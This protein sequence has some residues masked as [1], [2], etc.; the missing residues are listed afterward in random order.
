MLRDQSIGT[1]IFNP[2]NSSFNLGKTGIAISK[3]S[4]VQVGTGQLKERQAATIFYGRWAHT[5]Y[6]LDSNPSGNLTG[7]CP[8]PVPNGLEITDITKYA[9]IT[10][11]VGLAISSKSTQKDAAFKFIEY[12]FTKGMEE[13][14]KIGYNIPGNKLVAQTTFLSDTSISEKDKK[15]NEFFY[16]LAENHSFVIESNRYLS[17]SVVEN[18][19]FAPIFSSYFADSKGKEFNLG[20]WEETLDKIKGELQKQLDKAIKAN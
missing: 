16:E 14:A 2:N 18:N 11:M 7:F 9:G 6:S 17:Q 13:I 12:Y 15:I 10:A 8:P 1:P 5:T 20:L 3:Q 4:S 19:V